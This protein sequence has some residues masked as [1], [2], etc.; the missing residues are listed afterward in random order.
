MQYLV[1]QAYQSN[2][3]NL[4]HNQDIIL[5]MH[6][7]P[8]DQAHQNDEAMYYGPFGPLLHGLINDGKYIC[9]ESIKEQ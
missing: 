5:E 7:A 9:T 2:Q 3:N 4:V 6:W 8:E 1:K